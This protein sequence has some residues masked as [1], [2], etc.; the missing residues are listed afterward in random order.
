MRCESAKSN[1]H[2]NIP[3]FSIA[4][5]LAKG[6]YGNPF[7]YL[8]L[9]ETIRQLGHAHMYHVGVAFKVEDNFK[10]DFCLFKSVELICRHKKYHQ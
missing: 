2:I 6:R 9:E 1:P 10:F 7:C 4:E 3:L 8:P 5:L